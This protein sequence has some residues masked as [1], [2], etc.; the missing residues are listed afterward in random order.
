MSLNNIQ[1]KSNLLADLYKDSLVETNTKTM[2]AKRQV[3][4]LG[5]NQKKVLV[6]VSHDS[7]PFLPDHELTFLTNVLAACK[8]SIADIG[9]VNSNGIDETDLQNIIDLEARDIILFGVEPPDIGLPINFP[10]FQLQAFNNRTYLKAPT[11]TQ[12]ENDKGLKGSLWNSLKALL[13]I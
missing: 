13:K 8:M 3:K 1:L 5:N 9:I 11:L 4:Y 2:P 6:I 7:V 12:V 10:T